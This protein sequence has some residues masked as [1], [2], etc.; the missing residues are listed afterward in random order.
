MRFYLAILTF[1]FQQQCNLLEIMTNRPE[2]ARSR[3]EQALK[4][5]FPHARAVVN[6]NMLLGITCA[7]LGPAAIRELP[8]TLDKNQKVKQLKQ[9]GGLIRIK[10]FTLGFPD[11][12]LQLDLA[13]KEYQVL[14][15]TNIFGYK[16]TYA[17]T[18]N[19]SSYDEAIVDLSTA[20]TTSLIHIGTFRATVTTAKGNPQVQ[21]VSDTLGIYTAADFENAKSAEIATRREIIGQSF[22]RRGLELNDLELIAIKTMSIRQ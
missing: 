4:P 20:A 12:I 8:T 5:Y 6:G 7:D 10:T 14:P 3:A 16:N 22:A 18:C 15:A 13:T 1:A 19:S 2:F 17:A 21:T 11:R 9:F